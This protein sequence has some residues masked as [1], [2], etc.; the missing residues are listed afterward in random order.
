MMN[1]L[2]CGINHQT[3]PLALRERAYFVPTEVPDL[4][5]QLVSQ[6]AANEAVVLSTCNRTDFYLHGADLKR[7]NQLLQSH[8]KLND[9]RLR[10]YQYHNESALVHMLRVPIGLDSMLTGEPQIFGQYK[11][12]FELARKAGSVK[13]N[14]ERLFQQ[15]FSYSKLIRHQT[16]IGKNAISLS[17]IAIKLIKNIFADIKNC[18]ALLVGAGEMMELITTHLQSAGV[19]QITIANRDIRKAQVLAQKISARAIGLSEIPPF[20][21]ETE[22]LITATASQLPI[23]GK[24]AIER[25]LKIRRHRPIFMLD[26]AVPRDIEP[27]ARALEDVYLYSLDDLKEI[28]EKNQLSRQEQAKQAEEMVVVYSEYLMRKMASLEAAEVIAKLRNKIQ[29]FSDQELSRAQALLKQGRS[30]E[31]ILPVFANSLTNKILHAPS[32]NLRQAAE[33]KRKE[34]LLAAEILFNL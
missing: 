27:E 3:T 1:L 25:A 7:L 8:P 11:S 15:I 12:A 9:G 21:A 30:L 26:A 20:L 19:R 22:I 33:N 6:R 31:E 17:Y 29:A 14:F 10:W 24:G 34:V 13:Q 28:I 18:R 4:L 5:T 32:V 23:I 16:E 2:V